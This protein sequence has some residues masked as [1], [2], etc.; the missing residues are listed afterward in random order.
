MK[1]SNT[2]QNFANRQDFGY[3]QRALSHPDEFLGPNWK[4]VINF[5]LYL[6]N[7]S[8]EQFNLV[9]RPYLNLDTAV[10]QIIR[11]RARC[12]ARYVISES[13]SYHVYM[14]APTCASGFASRELI[15]AHKLLEQGFPLICTT[16]FLDYGTL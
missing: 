14:S 1:I 15:G 3:Q 9:E 8:D 5:W 13:I 10:R 6:D 7:L 4:E 11:E 16:L 2:H 12:A